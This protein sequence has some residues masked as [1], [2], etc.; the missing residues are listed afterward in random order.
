MK[1]QQLQ[2]SL[3]VAQQQ[4]VQYKSQLEVMNDSF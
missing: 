2:Q 3:E 1:I 4:E